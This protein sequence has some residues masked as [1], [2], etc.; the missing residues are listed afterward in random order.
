M[1][2]AGGGGGMLFGFTS[3]PRPISE[4]T[5]AILDMVSD[6]LRENMCQ[7][8]MF[9]KQAEWCILWNENFISEQKCWP[10][11]AIIPISEICEFASIEDSSK[12]WRRRE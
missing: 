2:W 8:L 3:A 6:E 9:A 11:K 5:S 10:H 7:K 1:V 12:K 4:C